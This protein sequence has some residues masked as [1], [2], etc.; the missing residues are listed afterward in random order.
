MSPLLEIY[1]VYMDQFAILVLTGKF[2]CTQ[3]HLL[4]SEILPTKKSPLEIYC[5]PYNSIVGKCQFYRNFVD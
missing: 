2:S 3:F 4:L 1:I 5:V